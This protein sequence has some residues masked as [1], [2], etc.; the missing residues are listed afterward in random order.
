[1]ANYF[2]YNGKRSDS[3][4][5]RIEKLPLLNGPSRKF[6][7]ASVPG[8]NG[9]IYQTEDAWNEKIQPYEI[10]AGGSGSG[11]AVT[12]FTAIKEWLHSADGYV[13]LQDSYDPTHYRKALFVDDMDIESMW[14]TWG[15]AT[16]NFRCKPERYIVSND[17]NLSASG[18][19]T[20]PTNHIAKPT[21]TLTGSNAGNQLNLD[22]TAES[23]NGH[24]AYFAD[25]DVGKYY[26]GAKDLM[27]LEGMEVDNTKVSS[28]SLTES[29]GTVSFDATA[30]GYGIALPAKVIPNCYYNL[31]FTVNS[32]CYVSLVYLSNNGVTEAITNRRT[33]SSGSNNTRIETPFDCSYILI[34]LAGQASGSYTFG[35][36]ML[37]LGASAKTFAQYATAYSEFKTI[38][39]YLNPSRQIVTTLRINTPFETAVID[40]ENENVTIEGVNG[41]PFVT[42]KDSN[43][44][45]SALFTKLYPDYQ[46]YTLTNATGVLTPNY[47]EL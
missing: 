34:I 47:W 15:R 8:L 6:Q 4:G 25:S 29:T 24:Y 35:S 11:D 18:S 41:N 26:V 5:I 43:N 2:E 38:K 42:V 28:A 30:S 20:N 17:I 46:S 36:L 33:F 21:I 23:T 16:I 14:H 22:R 32:A 13:V 1:M 45:P 12:S 44:K 27:D 40:C 10:F 7:S 3:F 39:G 31:S 37:N 19:I 9:N